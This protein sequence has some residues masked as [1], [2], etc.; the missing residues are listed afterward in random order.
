MFVLRTRCLKRYG[1]WWL[2]DWRPQP[3]LGL[4]SSLST[5]VERMWPG[6]G[7]GHIGIPRT[8]NFCPI[9][10]NVHN[11]YP[12][13]P[14]SQ[15]SFPLISN[16]YNF[17]LSNFHFLQLV[18]TPQISIP[19]FII[20]NVLHIW[21]RK[22]CQFPTWSKNSLYYSA[23]AAGQTHTAG[24]IVVRASQSPNHS[25][26]E[27]VTGMVAVALQKWW[28]CGGGGGHLVPFFRFY[29]TDERCVASRPEDW[30]IHS[31]FKRF[32]SYL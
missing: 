30:E 31:I 27:A 2:T 29:A 19:Q 9:I 14:I 15:I 11:F 26:I 13:F 10:F 18:T 3:N 1:M 8:Q 25:A 28:S 5:T 4:M 7:M 21:V 24:I 32:S 22:I 16:F 23:P 6:F 17:V 20:W 12:L